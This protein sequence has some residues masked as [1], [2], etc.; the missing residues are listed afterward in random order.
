MRVQCD[1]CSKR[2]RRVE[3]LCR[4]V[5]FSSGMDS[6][7]PH[8]TTCTHFQ[9]YLC[10]TPPPPP[11]TPPLPPLSY[12]PIPFPKA[13]SH[14]RTLAPSLQPGTLCRVA[15]GVGLSFLR[16]GG[17]RG[18]RGRGLTRRIAQT[19]PIPSWQA[20]ACSPLQGR[21]RDSSKLLLALRTKIS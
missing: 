2:M 11:P 20:L 10:R 21:V 17:G 19:S 16:H 7:T 14:R 5:A 9:C 18:G 12:F 3:H 6:K 13:I 1:K 15:R 8:A 4:R